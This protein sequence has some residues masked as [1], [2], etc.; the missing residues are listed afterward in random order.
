MPETE[1]LKK[2]QE[3]FDNELAAFVVDAML[4]LC[5]VENQNLSSYFL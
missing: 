4:P 1:K 5:V 3:Q 2:K